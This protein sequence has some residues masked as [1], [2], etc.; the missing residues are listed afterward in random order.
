M[1]IALDASTPAAV[2][3]AGGATSST[4]AAFSPPANSMI[5]VFVGIFATSATVAQSVSG[6]TNTGTAL[7][8]AKKVGANHSGS[9]PGGAAEIWWAYTTSAPGSITVTATYAA[10]AGGGSDPTDGVMAVKVFTGT[11][12]S[13]ASAASN[14]QINTTAAVPSTSITTT[15]ANSWVWGV[16]ANWSNATSP[17]ATSGQTIVDIERDTTNGDEA[18]TQSQSAVTPS[19]GTVVPI[20]VTSPSAL[21]QLVVIEILAATGTPPTVTG[22][23][24]TSGP[25]AGG[26]SVAITGTGFIVG[27][28]TVKFGAVTASTVTVNS[29]T[30]I[31][32]TSPAGSAGTVDV[33]VTTAGGTSATSSSD[34]FTYLAAPTVTGVSPS[35]G[36]TAGGTSVTITGTGFVIGASTVKFGA[37]TASATVTS[38]TSI[39][40]TSPAGSAGTVDVTVTTANGT[41]TTSTAD[42]FTFTSAS[43]PT[44]TSVTPNTGPSTGGTAGIVIGGT[45]FSSVTAVQFGGVNATTFSVTSTTAITATSPAGTGTVD[46]TVTTSAG[47]SATSSADQFTFI[48]PAVPSAPTLLTFTQAVTRPGVRQVITRIEAL[49]NGAV[50]AAVQNSYVQGSGGLWSVQGN[51]VGV[52]LSGGVKVD[53]TAQCRRTIDSLVIVDPRGAILPYLDIYGQ[54]IRLWR[55]LLLASGP[56]YMPLGTFRLSKDQTLQQPG[57]L[58]TVSGSDRSLTVSEQAWLTPYT[59]PAGTNIGAAI[60]SIIQAAIPWCPFSPSSFA[61]VTANVTPAAVTY[62]ANTDPFKTAV[63]LAQSAGLDLYFDA[64]GTCRLVTV[65]SEVTAAIAWSFVPGANCQAVTSGT[66]DDSTTAASVYVV[67]GQSSAS[68]VAPVTAMA[69]D[70]DPTSPTYIG[71]PFGLV[72]KFVTSNLISTQAGAQTYANAQLQLYS[73]RARRW[74]ATIVPNPAIKDNDV[75]FASGEWGSGVFITE[76]LS[77]PVGVTGSSNGMQVQARKVLSQDVR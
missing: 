35:S 51:P 52:A 66:I 40:A 39:T 43:S 8:W 1:A 47:T 46:V 19:S 54:E 24:P 13:L 60:Q 41:S 76:T 63:A 21:T 14:A 64:M 26:T 53:V 27:A 49:V 72:P 20:S 25:A 4:S 67:T 7:T 71:G 45:N 31:T 9:A 55:G 68:G 70:T 3:V 6:V 17:I 62:A 74:Q 65:Q 36:T 15:G 56:S 73:G 30:S 23:S 58:T 61:A 32:A 5:V 11:A 16:C 18:W 59:V 12:T 48:A 50:V 44:V 28:S 10:A 42:H 38:S 37:T 34:Q 22:V 57:L 69:M 29:A 33:T 75:L 2:S 77:I